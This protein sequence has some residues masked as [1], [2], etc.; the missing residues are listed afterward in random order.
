MRVSP[1]SRGSPLGLGSN[2]AIGHSIALR[3]TTKGPTHPQGGQ[4]PAVGE[5][6]AGSDRSVVL[7]PGSR[8]P[9]HFRQ[10]RNSKACIHCDKKWFALGNHPWD[11]ARE[12]RHR[13]TAGL[14]VHAWRRATSRI[15]AR[16]KLGLWIDQVKGVTGLS[17]TCLWGRT[18]RFAPSFTLLIGRL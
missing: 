17:A 10:V 1:A 14:R 2:R 11:R 7:I 18:A 15:L 12:P 9:S 4:K 13:R 6:K 16:F 3:S 5:R 8:R